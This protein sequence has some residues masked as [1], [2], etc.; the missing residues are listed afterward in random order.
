MG[1]LG[2]GKTRGYGNMGAGNTNMGG[3]GST[4]GRVMSR[5]GVEVVPLEREGRG[6]RARDVSGKVAEEGRGVGRGMWGMAF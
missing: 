2:I 3:R 1:S 6:V 4:G 5:S